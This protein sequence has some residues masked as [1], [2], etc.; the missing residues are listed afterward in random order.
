MRYLYESA[1]L[2]GGTKRATDPIWSV[3][4]HTISSITRLTG[5]PAIYRLNSTAPQ[6]GFTRQQ[7]QVMPDV[8]QL[9]PRGLN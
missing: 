6:R 4:T 5:R 2:E 7:L 1:E 3:T 8:T 9:P